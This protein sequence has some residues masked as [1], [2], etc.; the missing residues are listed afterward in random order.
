M[1]FWDRLPR[2]PDMGNHLASKLGSACLKSGLFP[3][4]VKRL[5]R[6]GLANRQCLKR[7][8]V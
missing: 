2:N 1:N 7:P 6:Q 4:S 5:V 8:H 3:D